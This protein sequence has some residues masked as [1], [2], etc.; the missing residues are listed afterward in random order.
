MTTEA[1]LD[2]SPSECR[3]GRETSLGK[4][5]LTSNVGLDWLR[6][7]LSGAGLELNDKHAPGGGKLRVEPAGHVVPLMASA[8]FR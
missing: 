3:W 1:V 5:S 7:S 4:S 6:R 2:S 8:G